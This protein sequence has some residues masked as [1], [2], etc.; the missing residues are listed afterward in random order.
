MEKYK[1]FQQLMHED[2]LAGKYD[3]EGIT[4][5]VTQQQLLALQERT[6]R[7]F[8]TDFEPIKKVA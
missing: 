4:G 6:H 2:V 8:K 3:E 5:P 7:R 1:S